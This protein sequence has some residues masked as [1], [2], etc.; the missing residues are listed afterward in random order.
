MNPRALLTLVVAV[1]L[2]VGLSS[3]ANARAQRTVQ[4][5]NG[6]TFNCLLCHTDAVG[7]GPRNALGLQ[8]EE[9]GLDGS[10]DVS[11]QAVVWANIFNLDADGDG[12]T[13]GEELGDPDG[14]W[15]PGDPDPATDD[16]SDPNDPEDFPAEIDANNGDDDGSGGSS[17]SE[18]GCSVSPGQRGQTGAAGGFLV[19]LIGL[20]LALRRRR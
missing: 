2:V 5:P 1:G 7:N 6:L 8:I 9:M 19:A 11:V 15:M 4:V 12:F 10:G 3:T 16:I 13:N 14:T 18:D 17:S 20:A